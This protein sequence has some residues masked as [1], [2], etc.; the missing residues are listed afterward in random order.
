MQKKLLPRTQSNKCYC[1]GSNTE[2][3]KFPQSP[4]LCS[5]HQTSQKPQKTK[6]VTA[7]FQESTPA[8]LKIEEP[9]EASS[10]PRASEGPTTT[11]KENA[12]MR[13]IISTNSK[14]FMDK[15]NLFTDFSKGLLFC[16]TLQ[17][18]TP[19]AIDNGRQYVQQRIHT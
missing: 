12:I 11:D 1:C 15:S 4:T 16:Q 8:I 7:Q 5:K 14:Y 6:D 13:D 18:E 17:S 19:A 2:Y 9:L 3:S 10:K